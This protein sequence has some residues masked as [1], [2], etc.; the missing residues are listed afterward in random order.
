MIFFSLC[1][2]P[3]L[4]TER[5]LLRPI[6]RSDARDLYAYARDPEVS[7]H[8]LWTPHAS[9]ADSR[10]F[11]RDIRRQYRK[12]FPSS[13]AIELKAERKMIGTIG[14]MWINPEF[15]SCEIGYSLARPYW[16]QGIMT[17]A[18]KEL[19]RYTF[20]SMRINRIEAMHEVDNPASGRVMEKAGMLCE[21]TLR[22]RV[23]NKGHYS[24]VQLYSILAC[25]RKT[26]KENEA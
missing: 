8:V 12:G 2:L 25:D 19:I 7:R 18:L 13:F 14:Y 15:R 10:A 20:E 4:E 5:L 24:D 6:R 9:I 22:Q 11:I 23:R 1:P 16:N 21:G 17:E 26:Q 3:V